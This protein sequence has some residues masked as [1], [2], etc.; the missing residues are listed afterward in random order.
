MSRLLP[1]RGFKVG[2]GSIVIVDPD[3]DYP[4]IE[5]VTPATISQAGSGQPITGT[6]AAFSAINAA[7][8]ATEETHHVFRGGVLLGDADGDESVLP[9]TPVEADDDVTFE[10]RSRASLSI[11][12]LGLTITAVSNASLA[13]NVPPAVALS[14]VT[15]GSV[16][17]P[18]TGEANSVGN[19]WDG[20]AY[21]VVPDGGSI[22]MADPLPAVSTIG[23]AVINGVMI[24]PLHGGTP[25]LD[26][27]VAYSASRLA[28]FPAELTAGQIVLKAI[29]QP[30]LR[31]GANG[32]RDGVIQEYA[33][34]H[35][36]SASQFAA[37]G[38]TLADKLSPTPWGWTGRTTKTWRTVTTAALL[39]ALGSRAAGASMPADL[40]ATVAR[41]DRFNPGL[42]SSYGLSGNL[43]YQYVSVH[44]FGHASSS[45]TNYGERLTKLMSAMSLLL[46]SDAA[47]ASKAAVL[48]RMI[49][50]GSHHFDTQKG[51]GIP[52]NGNGAH[53]QFM[54]AAMVLGL[55]ATGRTLEIPDIPSVAPENILSQPFIFD[56]A[57][58]ARLVPHTSGSEP[59]TYRRRAISIIN[60]NEICVPMNLGGEPS[61]RSW[62]GMQCRLANGTLVGTVITHPPQKDASGN[63][64]LINGASQPGNKASDP[65]LY[66]TLSSAAGL[67]VGTEVYCSAP[68]AIVAGDADWII[69][70]AGAEFRDY[71]PSATAVY[72]SLNTWASVVMLIR[73][74][75][76]FG[77]WCAALEAY[78]VRANT[79]N[80]PSAS[81]DFPPHFESTW[82]EAFWNTHWASLS[83]A[84]DSTPPTLVSS[85]P[86]DDATGVSASVT[87]SLTFNETV[88][89]GTGNI[90]LR[91]NISGTWSDLEAFNVATE[92][93]T[94]AGQISVAG[95]VVTLHPTAVLTPGRQYAIRVDATALDDLNGN[96][97]AGI[98]NDTAVSFTVAASAYTQAFVDTNGTA[99]LTH[100]AGAVAN[101]ARWLYSAWIKPQNVV[102]TVT[103]WGAN[104][105]GSIQIVA[106]KF[107]VIIKD[108]FAATLYDAT[109]AN[110]LTV[111]GLV[112]L[113]VIADPATG[114]Y[115]TYI[116]GAL[117]TM[118]VSVAAVTTANLIG[119]A[120]VTG[121]FAADTGGNKADVQV[122]D[123]F[124]QAGGTFPSVATLYGG[125]TP[126]DLTGVGTPYIWMGGDM[127]ADDDVGANA[128][129][130]WNDGF[131]KAASP[132]TLTAASATFTN[133]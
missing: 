64:I 83:A 131:N 73:A 15:Q 103:L 41:F 133:A 68:Y 71:T 96:S 81:I 53:L 101:N 22:V 50:L 126:P 28:I 78:V 36:L 86:A 52:E 122:S 62:N 35:I 72:R 45:P 56:A 100:T 48:R 114:T 89:F 34:C 95:N 112:H 85:S 1:S 88:Q 113:V 70:D 105:R 60:G 106:N 77:S 24:D 76:A 98:A 94:G 37:L 32:L 5:V 25:A 42:I 58:V 6:I 123:L 12:G 8:I 51:R 11:A 127:R 23:A 43:G 4:S 49:T 111:G 110:V 75:G 55:A 74:I 57:K 16:I 30:T 14:Q 66:V 115:Q 117:A 120:R 21:I 99:Y 40:A 3:A 63:L 17:F 33:V 128:A 20:A 84:G 7:G 59:Y 54:L 13:A 39:T 19:S 46:I 47:P 93:G 9:Y 124:L 91:Q 80:V 102:A 27:R 92:V 108:S 67:T 31:A 26:Q 129:H 97:F 125:G 29:S 104:G 82:A 65:R 132:I 90:T 116:N 18:F 119:L 69:E 44:D 118:T 109:A 38:S 107:R 130:G 87:P 121:L 61:Q 2:G 10:I 79:P